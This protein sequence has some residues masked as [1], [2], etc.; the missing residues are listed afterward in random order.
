LPNLICIWQIAK[1]LYH[2]L[3]IGPIVK[4]R[5]KIGKMS[6]ENFLAT[7]GY[8][9]KNVKNVR[10]KVDKLD[11]LPNVARKLAKCRQKIFWRHLANSQMSPENWQIVAR[12]F[13]GDIWLLAK[14][15]PKCKGK[16]RQIGPFAKCRQKIGKMSPENFLAT[17]GK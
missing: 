11:L 10:E 6:P 15:S 4:C 14:K 3:A 9:P 7:F 12:K 5:Q 13:S 16:R 1:K 8:L 2:Y 17:F